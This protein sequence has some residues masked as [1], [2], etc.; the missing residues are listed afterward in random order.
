MNIFNVNQSPRKTARIAGFVYL[1]VIVF[2]MF[3]LMYVRPELVIPGDAA[4]TAKNIME[5]ETLFR[6]GSVSELMLYTAF[7]LLP[8]PLYILLKSVNKNQAVLMV[9]F[10]AVSVPIGM[11][12]T[13]F[14]FAALSLLGSVDHLAVFTTDQLHAQMMFYLNLHDGVYL[15]GQ[16]FFGLWLFPLGYLVYKSGYFPKILGILVILGGFYQLGEAFSGMLIPSYEGPILTAIS[17]LSI[18]EILFCLYLLVKG[19]K[20]QSQDSALDKSYRLQP[21]K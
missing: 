14:N 10:V 7:L 13:L 2:G 11:L 16:I 5:S 4:A 9:L 1:L 17:V 3:G 21:E 8:L 6:L 19:V 15:I 20:D 18:S 12:S